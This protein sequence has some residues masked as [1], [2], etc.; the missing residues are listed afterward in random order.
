[1]SVQPHIQ[2]GREELAEY[3]ILPGDPKRVDRIKEFLTDAKEIIFHRE[4]NSISGYYKG[5]KVLVVSTGMGGASTGIVVEELHNI[6]VT[7]MIRVG[8]SGALQS[9]MVLGELVIVNGAVRDEGTSR[10]YVRE[11]YPAI[12]DTG[13]LCSMI[14]SVKGLGVKYRIGIARSHDSFYTD[15]EEEIDEY[16]SRKGVIAADMETAALFT[17]GGLRGVKTASVLNTVALYQGKV[18]EEINSYVNQEEKCIEGERNEILLALETIVTI[19][20]KKESES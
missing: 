6:G 11:M 12:P 9:D 13:C 17:I 5:I 7:Y 20:K 2:F 18:G 16:W 3:A 15:N 14:E 19:H 1:M 4:M 8:S 10:A